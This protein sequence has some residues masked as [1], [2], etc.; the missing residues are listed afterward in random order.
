MTA[1]LGHAPACQT[2]TC[3]KDAK[4][5][6]QSL[7]VGFLT[8]KVSCDAVYQDATA[9]LTGPG[10]VQL[11]VHTDDLCGQSGGGTS[12]LGSVML[13]SMPLSALP[14]HTSLDVIVDE[15]G[16]SLGHAVVQTP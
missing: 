3:W 15:A 4:P 1:A 7:V 12:A 13:V 6:S 16:G 10:V 8:A 11:D 5:V 2:A 9:H 14:R